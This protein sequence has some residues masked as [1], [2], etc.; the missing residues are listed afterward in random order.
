MACCPGPCCGVSENVGS[1]ELELVA[2]EGGNAD[3]TE[4]R[5]VLALAV[6][7]LATGVCAGLEGASLSFTNSLSFLPELTAAWTARLTSLSLVKGS[8]LP[9][10]RVTTS[11]Q[12]HQS[13][14]SQACERVTHT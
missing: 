6:R 10:V 1:V 8:S 7:E 12:H 3:G 2:A 9:C 13:M 14:E 11:Q 5:G 4:T